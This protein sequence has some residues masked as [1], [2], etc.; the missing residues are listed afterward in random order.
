MDKIILYDPSISTLNIGD[1]IICDS[2]SKYIEN[3]FSDAFYMRISTHLPVSVSYLKR[4]KNFDLRFVCGTNLLKYDMLKG[5]RQWDIG[6]HQAKYIGPAILLGCGWWQYQEK[7][8]LYSKLLFSQILSKDF[9]HSVRDQYTLLKL[10]EMGISNAINTGC[11]TMWSFTEDY[12]RKIPVQKANSA[13]TTLTDYKKNI[14]KDGEMLSFLSQNYQNVYLW[15][16]GAGDAQYYQQ[17]RRDEWKNVHLVSPSLKAYDALFEKED[18]E[19][20]G[21]RLHAGIRA[22]QHQKRSLI[23]AVDN[24]AI[25]KK[26]D[27]NLPVIARDDVASLRSILFQDQHTQIHIPQAE[28]ESYLSQFQNL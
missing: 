21:T 7:K 20:V 17:I 3:I 22:L 6:L 9:V 4:L 12:C 23:L 1:E 15:L 28:I 2:A 24:R 14:Q 16:Q 8:D 5:F 13:V 27:F 10:K 18:I 26:K 25:E 11:A 19:Y